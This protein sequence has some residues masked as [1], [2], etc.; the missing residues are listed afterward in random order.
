MDFYRGL[1]QHRIYLTSFLR[2]Q[3]EDRGLY[4]PIGLGRIY[5]VYHKGKDRQKTNPLSTMSTPELAAQLGHENGWTRSV[6]QRLLV[7]RRDPSI[8]P[9]LNGMVSNQRNPLAQLHALWTL[10]GMGGVEWPTIEVALKATHPKVRSAEIRV[11]DAVSYTHL[12][13]TKKA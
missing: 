4:E 7:E 2:G 3:I 10:D 13:L 5:R 12:K 6:A 1:I 11:S 9:T 8:I